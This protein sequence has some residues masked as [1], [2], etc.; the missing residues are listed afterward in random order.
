MKVVDEKKSGS[1]QD[2]YKNTAF[3]R[4]LTKQLYSEISKQRDKWIDDLFP[5]HELSIYSGKTDFSNHMGTFKVPSAIMVRESIIVR[6]LE[7][8]SLLPK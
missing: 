7:I 1:R 4:S 2:L 6:K 3:S 8:I 5:A